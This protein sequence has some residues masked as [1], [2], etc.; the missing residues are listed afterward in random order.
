MA[1]GMDHLISNS[2][3]TTEREKKRERGETLDRSLQ[4]FA[5]MP[6]KKQ[7]RQCQ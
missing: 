4:V 5:A 3:S 1:Q 2:T 6:V 7:V